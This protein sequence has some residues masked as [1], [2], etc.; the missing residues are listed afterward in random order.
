MERAQ[1]S[2]SLARLCAGLRCGGQA[3]PLP[4]L[5][6]STTLGTFCLGWNLSPHL[7]FPPKS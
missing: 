5:P 1:G 3:E 4:S 6:A 7:R 2:G